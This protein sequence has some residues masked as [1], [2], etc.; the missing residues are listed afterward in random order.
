MSDIAT[1]LEILD[2]EVVFQWNIFL[3]IRKSYSIKTLSQ[4]YQPD[5]TN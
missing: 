3:G 5:G 2:G 1:T 4:D